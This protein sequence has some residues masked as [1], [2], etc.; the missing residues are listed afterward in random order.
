MYSLIPYNPY[1]LGT[2]IMPPFYI[3]G[4]DLAP[5]HILKQWNMQGLMSMVESTQS[6]TPP[7]NVNL[8]LGIGQRQKRMCPLKAVQ[9]PS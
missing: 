9:F 1:E 4:L 3:Q 2:I 8:L 7:L 5:N 6:V